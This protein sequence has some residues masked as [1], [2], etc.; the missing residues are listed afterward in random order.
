MVGEMTEAIKRSRAS[1][2]MKKS[3][4]VPSAPSH[5]DRVRT[6]DADDTAAYLAAI[7]ESADDA[8]VSKTLTGIVTSWNASAQRM[9]GYTEQEMLGQPILLLIPPDRR[10][11]E[12]LILARIKAGKRTEHFE[13]VRVRKDGQLLHVSLTISPVRDATG[14]IIGASKIARDITERL[15]LEAAA[16]MSEMRLRLALDAAA[17]GTFIW[18]VAEDRT[19]SDA[20]MLALFGLPPDGVITLAQALST[21]IHQEDRNRYAEAVARA[22]AVEGDGELR[23]DIRIILPDT[24]QRWLAVVG[25]VFFEGEPRRPTS[26]AGAVTNITDRKDA[27]EA[28]QRA[29][30]ELEE[31]VRERTHELASA[32]RSLHRL[33]RQV[34]EAQETERRRLAR[35]LHD[36]VGQALTGVKM[37]LEI[38]QRQARTNGTSSVEP[39]HLSPDVREAIE[40]IDDAL[41]CVRDLSLEMRPAM[42]D[43][44]GLLPTFLWRFETYTRQTGIQVAFH[45]S[46][47]DQRFA[48]EVETGAYRIVQEALTNV[49]RH[50]AVP[51][52]RIQVIAT[53]GALRLYVVDEGTGFDAR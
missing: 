29:R 26:M 19:E 6:G 42:L 13:T 37:M 32:N 47:L 18:H 40:A 16:R 22:T 12:D 15:N 25:Q 51:I 30:N 53:E 4:T 28:L 8:I 33:S 17:M 46:G 1:A 21:M 48:P 14:A 27:E 3:A 41:T 10:S 49:A 11:E 7:V 34:L 38:S 52:V 23:E 50:A 36:E 20:R 35:E 31:R 45:H 24:S 2:R 44:L 9:F 43:S 39:T 5:S